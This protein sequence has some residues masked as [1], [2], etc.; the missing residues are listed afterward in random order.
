MTKH[1]KL[2]NLTYYDG[3]IIFNH[4]KNSTFSVLNKISC[5]PAFEKLSFV[6]KV[7]ENNGYTILW[8]SKLACPPVSGEECTI[9]HLGHLYDLSV[10]AKETWNWLARN[11]VE[12]LKGYQFHFSVCKALV[13]ISDP[14]G[15]R[16][17]M[18]DKDG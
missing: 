10:L 14:A 6:G 3:K 16:G 17:I 5:D 12:E 2:H 4:R 9:T 13:N 15:S 1:L 7:K 18:K 8:T 11:T